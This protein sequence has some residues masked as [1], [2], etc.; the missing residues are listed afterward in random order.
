MPNCRICFQPYSYQT[1][2]SFFSVKTVCSV[3]DLYLTLE[4]TQASYPL[5]NNTLITLSHEKKDHNAL[6]LQVFKAIFLKGFDCFWVNSRLEITP[7]ISQHLTALF[8]PLILY[9]SNHIPYDTIECIIENDDFY[10]NQCH[11][12]THV[13]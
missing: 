4:V 8:N 3:C 10:V 6:D 9:C 13:L 2:E 1:L 12:K 11:N 5:K 7:C